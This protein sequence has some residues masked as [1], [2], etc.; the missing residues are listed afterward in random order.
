[1]AETDLHQDDPAGLRQ[2]A[3][4]LLRNQST[5]RLDASQR[6][7]EVTL[8]EALHLVHELEVHQI[9]LEMQNE[10][11]RRAQEELA[12]S[13]AK[14]FDLYDLAP[15]GYLTLSEE[16][17]ILEANLTAANLLGLE[18]SRMVNR[19][20]TR[21]IVP[22]DQDIYYLHRKRLS[23]TLQP[24]VCEL[25]MARGGPTAP[26][27]PTILDAKGLGHQ[28]PRSGAAAF[29]AEPEQEDGGPLWVR[30][31]AA[32]TQSDTEA[33]V[34]RVTLSD[35]TEQKR[36]QDSLRDSEA[37]LRALLTNAPV[38]LFAV[39][40]AGLVTFAEGR[41]LAG[42]GFA[43][44]EVPGRLAYDLFAEHPVIRA[45]IQRA[46]AGEAFT[47]IAQI[48]GMW[49][50]IRLLPVPER[51][52]PVAGVIGVA[53]DVTAGKRAEDELQHAHDDLE[54]K[55]Q[56]RTADLRAAN[57]ALRQSHDQLHSLTRR[58][59][60][61]QE[62]ERAAIA[63]ELHDVA[64]QALT[65]MLLDLGA[66][67]RQTA[68]RPDTAATIRALR[69]SAD[70]LMSELHALAANLHPATLN[71]LGLLAAV[72]QH[73][74]SLQDTAGV[75]I[76]VRDDGLDA[77][78]LSPEVRIAVY[79]VIQEAVNNA[80]RHAEARNICV[81]LQRQPGRLLVTI[82]DDG[83]GFDAETPAEGRLGLLSMRERI[84]ML[85]G[86]LT[87]ESSPGAGT[88]VFVEVPL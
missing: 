70:G 43:P 64:G 11:L 55:V 8:G 60:E 35:I 47:L 45:A 61:V 10:E 46:L 3:E 85:S 72:R 4:A 6:G 71:R 53:M 20:L 36:T 5:N 63:R 17:L 86:S 52:H 25:R 29:Q 80:I 66:L 88:T 73:I 67:A 7:P 1:L 30:L 50:D 40:G 15:V 21:F 59:V 84:E 62:N 49:F 48:A 75:Q 41:G 18:R 16:G 74:S 31:Q 2:R 27:A 87:I 33:P 79:R 65:C 9:E 77:N 13:R 24:Q 26:S 34:W 56:E 38:V 83:S 23:A 81:L 54:L 22:G 44:E 12:L 37:R 39:D 19:P 78:S 51:D 76:Q 32:V 42:M 28:P 14:Y 58:L 57:D 82:E 69:G 68:D